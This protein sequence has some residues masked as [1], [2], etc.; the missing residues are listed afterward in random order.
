M[1][2]LLNALKGIM[3]RINGRVANVH[4]TLQS[5]GWISL[6][7][8]IEAEHQP[9]AGYSWQREYSPEEIEQSTVNILDTFIADVH[10]LMEVKKCSSH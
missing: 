4:V 7:V 1:I 6:G 10:K 9:F 5:D 2:E 3:V 8:D